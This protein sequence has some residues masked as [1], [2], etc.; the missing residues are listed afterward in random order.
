MKSDSFTAEQ[1]HCVWRT[2]CTDPK[3]CGRGPC[4]QLEK[5]AVSSKTVLLGMD[6]P[7]PLPDV[8]AKLIEATEHL[9][10]V[11]NCDAHGHEEFRR[12]RIV[13][14]QYLQAMRAA[15]ETAASPF[16]DKLRARIEE[17]RGALYTYGDFGNAVGGPLL[18]GV[19]DAIDE[20]SAEKASGQCL[21]DGCG[22][23]EAAPGLGVCSEHKAV[24]EAPENYGKAVFVPSEKTT[25]V[26][27]C[28]LCS[29]IGIVT[30]MPDGHEIECGA[31]H[32]T[33]SASP[34]TPE[35]G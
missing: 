19:L 13:G 1:R 4:Q 15:P 18:D 14:Q 17:M 30:L 2:G 5:E 8:L 21:V 20:L 34:R 16:V 33:G 6:T 31:C 35:H 23:P 9:L 22:K 29:G 32:G 12:A 24:I 27:A 25:P 3:R 26:K 7:W 28:P 11:H 10:Y